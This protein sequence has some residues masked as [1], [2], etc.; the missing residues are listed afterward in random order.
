MYLALQQVENLIHSYC[1]GP[2]GSSGVSLYLVVA[3]V[4]HTENT[5]KATDDQK[6]VQLKGQCPMFMEA[7]A[8]IVL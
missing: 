1:P 8:D 3:R 2:P 7:T 6:Y 5:T 4:V